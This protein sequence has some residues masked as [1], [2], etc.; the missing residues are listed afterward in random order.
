[1]ENETWGVVHL[2]AGYG[3]CAGRLVDTSEFGVRGVQID[4]PD[5]DGTF[6]SRFFSAAI[7]LSVHKLP[8]ADTRRLI[9]VYSLP[10]DDRESL[11][12]DPEVDDLFFGL[13][14]GEWHDDEAADLQRRFAC[15]LTQAQLDGREIAASGRK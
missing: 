12:F 2:S 13:P 7:V 8:E 5:Q 1:M 11:P 10:N 9:G 15:G 3:R 6:A 4:V 14:R